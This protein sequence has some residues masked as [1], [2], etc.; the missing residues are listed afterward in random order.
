MY[1]KIVPHL[2][3]DTEAKEAVAF[4]T[5]IFPDSRIISSHQFDGPEGDAERVVFEL[6]GYRFMS[7]SSG[8]THERNATISFL[9]P[10]LE[11]QTP[12]VERLWDRLIDGGS[13]IMDIGG[14][15]FNEK[16]GW[17][18]DKYN[19]SWLFYLAT[20]EQLCPYSIVP[21]V[22]FGDDVAGQAEEAMKFYS[23]VFNRT[24]YR[25][26]YHYPKGLGSGNRDYLMHGE[27]QLEG[28]CFGF[29]DSLQEHGFNFNEGISLMVHCDNQQEIDDYW[30]ELSTEPET[31]SCG[32][33]KDKYGMHWQ[34][35]P[36]V[37]D[38]MRKEGS[39]SALKSLTATYLKMKKL[40]I[41]LLEKAYKEE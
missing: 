23:H 27:L 26:V 22:M 37:L 35:V 2:W 12:M 4:Y 41:S 1:Q 25:G 3:F 40:D 34:V 21:V 29:M 20:E 16:F 13:P 7:V 14:Y 11:Y 30:A 33:L 10:Y 38:D 15:P 8:Q 17:L 39:A 24:K 19:I 28:Q 36:K 18:E 6:L 31:E 9:V 32:W 5:E